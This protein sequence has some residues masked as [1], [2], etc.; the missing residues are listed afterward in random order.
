MKN[1]NLG[2]PSLYTFKDKE[3]LNFMFGHDVVSEVN[4]YFQALAKL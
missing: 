3:K 1:E 2:G 4:E